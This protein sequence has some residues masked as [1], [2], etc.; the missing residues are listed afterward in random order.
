MTRSGQTQRKYHLPYQMWVTIILCREPT[1]AQPSPRAA[2][3]G[4]ARGMAHRHGG[5]RRA[6]IE[7]NTFPPHQELH[8][9][10]LT[11][12]TLAGCDS[13]AF[14]SSCFS[15]CLYLLARACLLACLRACAGVLPLLG[16]GGD[17][18]PEA[19]PG[20]P[21]QGAHGP[22]HVRTCLTTPA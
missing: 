10:S 21:A 12:C 1:R 20:R 6:L 2:V 13:C 17:N 18:A 5:A 4:Q 9:L 7:P 15:A 19:L 22:A 16:G 11:G 14:L 8:Q 3:R